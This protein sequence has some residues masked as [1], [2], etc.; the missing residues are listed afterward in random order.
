MEMSAL[1]TS[2]IPFFFRQL[3]IA[4]N[5]FHPKWCG[6]AYQ[7][8]RIVSFSPTNIT[9]ICH[10]KDHLDAQSQHHLKRI[11]LSWFRWNRFQVVCACFSHSCTACVTRKK[12]LKINLQCAIQM[13]I[14]CMENILSREEKWRRRSNTKMMMRD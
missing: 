6:L 9:N 3:S 4:S 14:K 13:T 7:I 8:H 5:K 2:S 10:R 1:N 12:K 11:D